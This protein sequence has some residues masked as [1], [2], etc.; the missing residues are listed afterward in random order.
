M[1]CI[2]Y[3]NTFGY[4]S[5]F[6]DM[7]SPCDAGD[8]LSFFSRFFTTVSFEKEPRSFLD[9][10]SSSSGEAGGIFRFLSCFPRKISPLYGRFFSL[11]KQINLIN[12]PHETGA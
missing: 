10:R 2:T 8:S 5:R 11:G 4:I 3:V 9:T 7:K 12:K 1:S 6:T